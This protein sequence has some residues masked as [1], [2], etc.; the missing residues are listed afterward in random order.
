MFVSKLKS[1]GPLIYKREER[2]LAKPGK[3]TDWMSYSWT[4]QLESTLKIGNGFP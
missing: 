4:S 2:N 3:Q 1:G